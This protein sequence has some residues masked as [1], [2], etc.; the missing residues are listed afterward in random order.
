[1]RLLPFL[2]PALR[3]LSHP[4]AVASASACSPSYR[5]CCGPCLILLLSQARALAPL[6]TASA[7]ALVSSYCCRTRTVFAPHSWQ[8]GCRHRHSRELDVPHCA[9]VRPVEDD[10]VL[11]HVRDP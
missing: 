3:P 6:P 10:V 9:L 8:R 5:Q 1:E 11:G 4:I 2:P 7:A